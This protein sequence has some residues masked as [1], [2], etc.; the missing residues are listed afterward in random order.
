MGCLMIW[1]VGAALDAL[2][3]RIDFEAA[4]AAAMNHSGYYLGGYGTSERRSLECQKLH[5]FWSRGDEKSF[6]STGAEM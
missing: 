3:R 1:A 4:A 5:S 2:V 6:I